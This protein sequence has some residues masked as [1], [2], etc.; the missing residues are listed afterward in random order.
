M[1]EGG[2]PRDESLLVTHLGGDHQ[3]TQGH[4]V[5]LGLPDIV[6]RHEQV[7]V[8]G[9]GED[10]DDNLLATLDDYLTAMWTV[11]VDSS[12]ST[13]RSAVHST[14]CLLRLSW[15]DLRGTGLTSLSLTWTQ[16]R[17]SARYSVGL[18]GG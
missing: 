18:Y 12:S 17:I 7:Q 13:A 10:G 1:A 15:G 5:Q 8:P 2:Q 11:R 6:T 9:N 14:S 4:Q 16:A 3:G